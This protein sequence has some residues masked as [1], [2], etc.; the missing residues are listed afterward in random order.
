MQ[1]TSNNITRIQKARYEGGGTEKR[2][3]DRVTVHQQEATAATITSL[4]E[5][6]T[7]IKGVKKDKIKNKMVTNHTNVVESLSFA[8][9]LPGETGQSRP[10]NSP[11][12]NL[13]RDECG[14]RRGE[15]ER[16]NEQSEPGGISS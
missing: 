14:E 3:E 8:G 4:K 13:R 2:K 1:S 7:G 15:G 16:Q 5:I 10:K 9:F 11:N 6:T 12:P